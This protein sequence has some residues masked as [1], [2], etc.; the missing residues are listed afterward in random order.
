MIVPCSLALAV[1]HIVLWLTITVGVG[2]LRAQRLHMTIYEQEVGH[3]KV[4]DRDRAR[5]AVETVVCWVTSA[6]VC[7]IR[8]TGEITDQA[9]PGDGCATHDGAA[10]KCRTIAHTR[11][12][13]G[14]V[15][16]M[17]ANQDGG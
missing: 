16:M 11:K 12:A 6:R 5:R 17:L 2:R 7:P 13:G 1:P 14:C 15:A 9:M 3:L 8:I 10:S 4:F